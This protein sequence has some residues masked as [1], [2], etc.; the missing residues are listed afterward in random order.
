MKTRAFRHPGAPRASRGFSLVELMVA[1]AVGLLVALAVTGAVVTAGRQAS[2]IG[3]T[4]ATQN[5]AQVGLS[6]MDLSARAA[7][8]GFYSSR[9]PICP[10]WNAWNGSAM[11]SDGGRFMPARIVSGGASGASDTL[12][13]TGGSGHRTLAAAPVM[14]DVTGA[15]SSI[16]VTVSDFESG[17]LAL[18]GAPGSGQPC[19]L[20]EVSQAPSLTSVCGGHATQCQ[21]L[22]RNPGSGL[23]SAPTAYAMRPV[24]GFD[25]SGLATAAP[26]VVSRVGSTASGFH[27]DAYTV[28]CESLVRYDAFATA[29]PPSCSASPLSFGAGVDAIA[30]GIVLLRA[31]YGVSASAESDVVTDWV[32]AAGPDWGGTPS[33]A[34]IG[35]IKAVRVVLVARSSEPEGTAVT[36]PCTNAAGVSNTGPCSFEDAAAPAINVA[37]APLPAGRSWQNYRYRVHTAILPLRSVIWSD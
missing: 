34:D 35:R 24:Y 23:N 21:Q 31:Q 2:V 1:S 36:A 17:D 22:V 26:A 8:A 12:V 11:V 32:D 27:Q 9:Q 15:G 6:L 33:A 20:F 13:L 25:D 14:T 16:K 37:S 30:T 29:T 5:S 19:T 4:A 18:I 7:G 28:Q 10:T 3:S